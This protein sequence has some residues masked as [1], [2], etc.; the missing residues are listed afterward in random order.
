MKT[1]EIPWGCWYG[2]GTFCLTFPDRFAL[3]LL[4]MPDLDPLS[5]AA[6][7]ES[8][9]NPVDSPRVKELASQAAS[10][11]IAVDDISRPTRTSEILP[12]LLRELSAVPRDK[13]TIYIA[14]GAHRPMLGQELRLKL[15][16]EVLQTCN[17]V[18]HH[19]YE[20]LV[21]LGRSSRGTPVFINRSFYE[22]DL[23]IGVGAVLPHPY[24]GYSGGGKVVLP[25]LAGIETLRANHE[26]AVTGISGGLGDPN[27]EARRD[28][29]EIALQ[30]GLAFS[31][32]IVV[33][34]RRETVGLVSGHPITAHRRA[35]CLAGDAYATPLV[36]PPYEIVVLNAYPKDTE[37][38]Q[39]GNVFNCYRSSPVPL[40]TPK[41]TLVVTSRCSTGQGF[42][43]LHGKS[44]RLYRQ[45]G[46]KK[47]LEG[48]ELLFFSPNISR[49]DF[50]V[51]FSER[52]RFFDD[53]NELAGHLEAR[54]GPSAR[55]GVFPTAPLQIPVLNQS[56]P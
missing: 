14:L 9:C 23:K 12:A 52:Y 55:V 17:V 49:G 33:N 19:P 28:I 29:E 40:L 21:E 35:A 30:A 10:V 41:G 51:S 7:A 15:G 38:L 13:V 48:R 6:I 25:G 16:E 22:A 3:S 50:A 26:P 36:D 32:N 53:W 42:H 54:H 8:I 47:F 43:S 24:A 27:V 1:V 20:N 46:E 2:D 45:P 39:A 4:K 37:L 31:C 5:A 44:M 56:T 18:Q 34:A 11:A